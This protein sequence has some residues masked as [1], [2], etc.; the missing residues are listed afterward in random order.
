MQPFMPYPI[1]AGP[2]AVGKTALAVRLAQALD[3]EVVSADS[4]QIYAGISVG[5]ARPAKEETAGVPHHLQGFLPLDESYSVAR[6]LEDASRVF[7]DI[8]ARGRT[9]VM[10]GGT[11][12]Y[13]QSFMENRQLLPQSG[14]PAVRADLTARA[15]RE[16]GAALLAELAAVDPETAARLHENDVHRIVRALEVYRTTGKT[17]AEQARAS[18]AVPSPYSGCLIVL[19]MRDRARLY[20]RIDRRVDRMLSDGLIDEARLVLS[21]APGATV[22]QAIG[23][24]ELLPY[25]RGECPLDE[26][27]RQLKTG[28]RHYAKRQLSWFS[29]MPQ[30]RFLY[31][32]DYPDEDALT[33]AA[34]A[35]YRGSLREQG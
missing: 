2:T 28:T 22:L 31:A 5:T 23:Y 15:A 29:R 19:S 10:C 3:G 7:A 32:D 30:A 24:K 25:L 6:Y 17:I 12:L 20:D 18:L 33:A 13:V 16:G 26:A 35:V 34:L 1:V 14:D 27:V 9:P 8:F 4:M 11:G 21:A